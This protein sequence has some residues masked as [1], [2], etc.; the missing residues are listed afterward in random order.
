M[1]KLL[2]LRYITVLISLLYSVFDKYIADKI[3]QTKNIKVSLKCL[4][5]PFCFEI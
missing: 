1:S 5:L 4:V 2:F 3:K